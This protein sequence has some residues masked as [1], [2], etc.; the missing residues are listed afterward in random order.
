[1]IEFQCSGCGRT[2]RADDHLAG[3]RSRCKTCG[4]ATIVPTPGP[5]AFDDVPAP[6]PL[7]RLAPRQVP[8]DSPEAPRRRARRKRK[9]ATIDRD[10]WIALGL[11]A[12]L[13]AIAM[14]VPLLGFVVDVLRTVIHELGHTATAWILGS[15]AIPSFDLSF[16]GGVS[17]ILRRQPLLIAAIYGIF[18]TLLFRSRDDRPAMVG[19]LVGVGAYSAVVFTPVRDMMILAMGHGAELVIAG[20]FLYRALSGSQVL[21]GEERPLYAFLG[22]Y[23]ILADARFA[24]GLISNRDRRA[25]YEDAKGG[26]H[27]MD[28]SRLAEEY[29]HARLEVVAGAFLLACALTIAAA[30]L[31]HRYGRRPR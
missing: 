19:L 8:A 29:L 16:G 26:G 1:M 21:R 24:H 23:M 3:L 28:F 27:Q 4:A 7:P 12:G 11:G 22:L 17:H 18:A 10:A 5:S 30:F 2:F 9:A 6:E 15:P 31:V 20:I 13:A 14:A 25:E